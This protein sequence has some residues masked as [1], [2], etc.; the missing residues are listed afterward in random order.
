MVACLHKSKILNS[1]AMSYRYHAFALTNASSRLFEQRALQT[2]GPQL[3]FQKQPHGDMISRNHK[4][5][6]TSLPHSHFA[7]TQ[8]APPLTLCKKDSPIY[9]YLHPP[10]SPSLQTIKSLPNHP[11][12]SSLMSRCFLY[13]SYHVCYGYAPHFNLTYL[14]MYVC[15]YA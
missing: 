13:H 7:T 12:L 2:K 6:I 9:S 8:S 5:N 3:P 1:R 15:M 10:T 4:A 11:H 14:Y